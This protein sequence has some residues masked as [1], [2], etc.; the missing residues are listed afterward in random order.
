MKMKKIIE[1]I[2]IITIIKIIE[3]IE[4]IKMIKIIKIFKIIKIM[5]C[6]SSLL[7]GQWSTNKILSVLVYI[8]KVLFPLWAEINNSLSFYETYD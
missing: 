2:I 4:M 5:S 1:I 7:G 8:F 3:I 6:M